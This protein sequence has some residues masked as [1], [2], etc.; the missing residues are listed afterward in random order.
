MWIVDDRLADA[1]ALPQR[2]GVDDI[3][4]ILQDKRLEEGGQ[5]DFSPGMICPIGR[6]GDDMLV[7]GTYAPTSPCGIA[8]SG[9]ACWTG[10]G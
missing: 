5:L 2:Y 7:N 4:L 3:P 1:L 8:G 10:G 6:L 9:S